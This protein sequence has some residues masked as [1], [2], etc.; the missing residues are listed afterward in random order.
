MSASVSLCVSA[1]VCLCVSVSV[2]AP[3]LDG[4]LD[5]LGGL[6]DEVGHHLGV[7]G[8]VGGGQGGHQQAADGQ[9]E[10]VG[11]GQ[12]ELHRAAVHL[13][14]HR[15]QQPVLHWGRS[16][17]RGSRGVT[18]TQG[19]HEGSQHFL[20]FFFLSFKGVTRGHSIFFS[21]SFKGVTR[22]HSLF[23]LIG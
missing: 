7:V 1:S 6:A 11:G 10:G 13:Q 5:E 15:L 9:V 3:H 12:L 21:F 23:F 4:L 18:A 19:G 17:A 14:H 20:F 22:G 16:N 8:V 2:Q